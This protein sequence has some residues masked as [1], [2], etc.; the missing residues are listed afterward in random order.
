MQLCKCTQTGSQ[1]CS[2]PERSP[3]PSMCWWRKHPW[4]PEPLTVFAFH[5]SS[6]PCTALGDIG[7]HEV[8]ILNLGLL[9]LQ[10]PFCLLF[11][12]VAH[13]QVTWS[14]E[15]RRKCVR[16]LSARKRIAL[17]PSGQ[18]ILLRHT[19]KIRRTFRQLSGGKKSIPGPRCSPFFAGTAAARVFPRPRQ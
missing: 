9:I 2:N 14:F 17:F 13:T 5:S 7:A 8:R 4:S 12:L 3:R 19:S 10:I 11:Q 16:R 15:A 6:P 1:H 18:R